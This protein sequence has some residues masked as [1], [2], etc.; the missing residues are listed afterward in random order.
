LGDLIPDFGI[1]FKVAGIIV[2]EIQ[3]HYLK[4]NLQ[5]LCELGC[6]CPGLSEVVA[7][8]LT[9]LKRKY[10]MD[11]DDKGKLLSDQD[12]KIVKSIMSKK[13]KREFTVQEALAVKD[14]KIVEATCLRLV[15]K[16]EISPRKPNQ[17]SYLIACQI[18]DVFKQS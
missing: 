10:I 9:I 8:K 7:R 17:D 16:K 13:K 6:S 5:M 1:I 2:G 3:E 12:M 11:L 4:Q 18:A 15:I 14:L